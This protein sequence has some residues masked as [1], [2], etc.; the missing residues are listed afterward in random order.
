MN[1]SKKCIV[2]LKSL[3][4]MWTMKTVQYEHVLGICFY[5]LFFHNQIKDIN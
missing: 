4:I 5:D 3:S 1:T 2:M